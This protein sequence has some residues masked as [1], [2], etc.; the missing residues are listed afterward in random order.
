MAPG[1]PGRGT[2][3]GDTN[4]QLGWAHGGHDL[5][6]PT[7][8]SQCP[9]GDTIGRRLPAPQCAIPGGHWYRMLDLG[10]LIAYWVYPAI[11][12]LVRLSN[13]GL[14]VPDK[15]TLIFP[16]SLLYKGDFQLPL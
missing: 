5:L 11:F 2:R 8:R 6:R 3:D 7:S 13:I 14:P 1:A 10:Q 15:T 4:D 9:T 16:C 12:L